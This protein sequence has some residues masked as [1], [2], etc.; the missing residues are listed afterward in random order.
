MNSIFN[1]PHVTYKGIRDVNFTGSTGDQITGKSLMFEDESEN[2]M[3]FF[4]N[5]ETYNILSLPQI[6]QIGTIYV[7]I[8]DGYKGAKKIEFKRFE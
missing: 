7:R 8:K 5:N 3:S 1:C 2:E 6:G 4:V